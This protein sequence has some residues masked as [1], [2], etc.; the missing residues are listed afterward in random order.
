[1]FDWRKAEHP[2][3]IIEIER[4]DQIVDREFGMGLADQNHTSFRR[5]A[6]QAAHRPQ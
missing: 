6:N 5:D 1:V 4:S 2:D 3:I